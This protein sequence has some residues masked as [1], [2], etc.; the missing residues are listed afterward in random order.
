MK[1]IRRPLS[2]DGHWPTAWESPSWNILQQETQGLAAEL[3]QGQGLAAE[4]LQGQGLA[5]E[6]LQGQRLA[7]ELLQG[8]R[9]G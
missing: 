2:V 4:L 3:L 9:Q 1:C 7:A 5:A 6:L 8:Q